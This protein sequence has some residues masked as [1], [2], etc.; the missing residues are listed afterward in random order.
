MG[1]PTRER[2][3]LYDGPPRTMAEAWMQERAA[4]QAELAR[5][6]ALL[7][8]GTAPRIVEGMFRLAQQYG[9]SPFAAEH[10]LSY[11]AKQLAAK[12]AEIAALKREVAEGFKV[13]VVDVTGDSAMMA[14]NGRLKAELARLR[15]DREESDTAL[16]KEIEEKDAELARLRDSEIRYT[17]LKAEWQASV[18]EQVHAAVAAE[19]ERCISLVRKRLVY[20]S[21]RAVSWHEI[22]DCLEALAPPAAPP[23]TKK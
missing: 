19:R 22:Q 4:M 2:P 21:Q 18:T 20:D 13:D 3:Y 12:D 15:A 6:Q 5:V 17:R 1:D 16:L 23:E 9:Q 7:E 8:P 10:A 14:E 11:I